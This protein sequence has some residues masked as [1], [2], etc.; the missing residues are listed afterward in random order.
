MDRCCQGACRQASFV[1]LAFALSRDIFFTRIRHGDWRNAYLSLDII[2]RFWTTAV[3]DRVLEIAIAFRTVHESYQ[4]FCQYC[5]AVGHVR[6]RSFKSLLDKL[7][8]S[9]SAVRHKQTRGLV[10]ESLDLIKAIVQ[11]LETYLDTGGAVDARHLECLVQGTLNLSPVVDTSRS[12]KQEMNDNP[13]SKLVRG[14]VLR[15]FRLFETRGVK[16]SVQVCTTIAT[17]SAALRD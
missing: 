5:K 14:L 12:E 17:M 7:N 8:K 9:S 2:F 11:A 16:P 1:P 13:T 4:I 3:D 6:P 10:L 15:I